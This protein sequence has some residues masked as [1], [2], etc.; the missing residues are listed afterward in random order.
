MG[1]KEENM[2]AAEGKAYATIGTTLEY[3]T[4]GSSGW[5]ELSKIKT[6]PELGGTPEQIETTDLTD[7]IQ[8]FVLGVQ[9][10]DVMEFEANYSPAAF[11]KVK[12]QEGKD[13]H[14][15]VKLG[16]EGALGSVK[17]QGQHSVRISEGEVNGAIGMIISCSASTVLDFDPEPAT[18]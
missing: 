3:S 1:R 7:E 18:A 12:E 10:L 2:A 13:L 16:K 17:W 5:T 6:F 9:Q 4:D 14:Y 15:R 11:Q 8:T